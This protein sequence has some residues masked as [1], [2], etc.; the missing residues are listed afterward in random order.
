MP[1]LLAVGD[2]GRD[3]VESIITRNVAAP[4]TAAQL[5]WLDQ[6]LGQSIARWKLV[7]GHL[8]LRS[9]ISGPGETPEMVEMVLPI[10]RPPVLSAMITICSTS[11]QTD[12]TT[13]AAARA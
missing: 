9:D 4:D 5:A 7:A 2:R 1:G 6:V 3:K 11:L 8:T 12:C 13:P 10:L